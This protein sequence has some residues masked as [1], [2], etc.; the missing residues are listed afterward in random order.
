MGSFYRSQRELI[1]VFRHGTAPHRNTRKLGQHG[2]YR[3]SVWH[4]S[5]VNTRRA[6]RMADLAR[7]PTVKP[8]TLI[9][10]AIRDASGRGKIVLNGFGASGLTLI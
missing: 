3:T 5:G 4:Y 9:A 7:Y 8:V 10:D 2:C 1:L 6:D